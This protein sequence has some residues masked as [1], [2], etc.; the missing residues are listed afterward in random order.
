[1]SE[2]PRPH[3]RRQYFIKRDFQFRFILKF[4][5]IVLAG[6]IISTGLLFLFS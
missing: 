1:M 3:R 6:V 4:C 2:N 5:L